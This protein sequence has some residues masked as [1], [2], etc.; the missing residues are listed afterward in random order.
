MRGALYEY[1]LRSCYRLRSTSV[2]PGVVY[3]ALLRD[4]PGDEP[5][6]VVTCDGDVYM[7]KAVP[8]TVKP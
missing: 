5:A 7:R 8:L 3:V 4:D 2:A 1:V 6:T